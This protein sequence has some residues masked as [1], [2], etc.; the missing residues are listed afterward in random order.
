MLVDHPDEPT[1]AYSQQVA[2][3]IGMDEVKFDIQ[4]WNFKLLRQRHSMMT[5]TEMQQFAIRTN[6]Y[7]NLLI[8]TS[9]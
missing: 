9:G 2:K 4:L 8:R 7:S 3:P 6:R 1:P 5:F